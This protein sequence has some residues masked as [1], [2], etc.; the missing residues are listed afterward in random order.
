MSRVLDWLEER[1]GVAV[2]PAAE[3]ERLEES[4]MRLGAFADQAED[5]AITVYDYLGGRPHEMSVDNRRLLAQRSRIAFVRDP[6]AGAEAS[7]R[8][9][10]SLGRGIPCPKAADEQVQ[11]V[12]DQFWNDANNKRKLTTVA[13]QRKRSNNLLTTANS[14]PVA[15]EHSGRVRIGFVD[16]DLVTDI[17]PHS[18][19]EETPLW[20]VVR[21]K[22]TKWDYEQHRPDYL[23]PQTRDGL[24]KVYYMEHWRN[25]EDADKEAEEADDTKQ[26]RPPEDHILDGKVEHFAINVVGRTQFGVPPWARTLRFFSAMN[27]LTEAQVQMRQAAATIV[28]KRVRKTDPKGI[29][30]G[31]SQ[32]IAATGQLATEGFNQSTGASP[33][34]GG[35]GTSPQRGNAPPPAGSWWHENLSDRLEAVRLSS[36]A[37]EAA[38]DAQLTRAPIA[39]ASGFGQ[40]YLGDPSST[41]LAT[42]STLELPTMMEIQAW[43]EVFESMIRWAV[44]YAIE[45]AIEHGV[46][47]Q[48]VRDTDTG[49]PRALK[50]LHL[51]EDRE[52]LEAR[53]GK[54]LSYSFEM[55][56]PGRRNLPDVMGAVGQLGSALNIASVSPAAAE[57][58]LKFALD[59]GF[60]YDD[61]ERLTERI[62]GEV[63]SFQEDQK[64][65]ERQMAMAGGQPGPGGPQP[66]GGGGQRP[67]KD[68]RE[69]SDKSQYGERRRASRP[70]E[71]MASSRGQRAREAILEPDL[72]IPY[73]VDPELEAMLSGDV[74]AAFERM[75]GDPRSF[76]GQNGSNGATPRP[77]PPSILT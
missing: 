48:F 58:A 61:S 29:L 5:L 54:D 10:F 39:A 27:Q 18:E 65:M 60:Q 34:A 1:T 62:M 75:L 69:S 24:E 35:P 23:T 77:Q 4:S 46:L 71:E 59:H 66:P 43:Q 6:L 50:E 70:P 57:F 7:L 74:D 26:K 30:K 37:G 11:A 8:A 52:E 40:H 42:A 36:G 3:V 28:A 20:Y 49:D 47:G 14:Y 13:A 76:L 12:I 45:C 31:A 41:N 68:P 55:P 53:V 15:F 19:D 32:L 16:E 2:R 17:V 38:T 9:N 72:P 67:Q 33:H 56:Y 73:Y 22:T 21:K 25:V 51:S 64:E 63:K 44:D